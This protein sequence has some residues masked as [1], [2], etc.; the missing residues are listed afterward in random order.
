MFGTADEA[1]EVIGLPEGIQ[2]AESGFVDKA[3]RNAFPA[4]ERVGERYSIA[5]GE[6][7][8]NVIGHDDVAPQLVALPVEVMKAVSDDLGEAWIT[9][10]AVSVRGIEVFIEFVGELAV[11]AGF[12]DFV[13]R[14]R[15]RSE[16]GVTR[17][18][19]VIK[20]FTRQRIGQPKGDKDRHLALL[21]VRQLVGGLFDVPSRIEELHA[22]ANRGER[23]HSCPLFKWR[24]SREDEEA[25]RSVRAPLQLHASACTFFEAEM[26]V[27]GRRHEAEKGFAG[28]QGLAVAGLGR[29]NGAKN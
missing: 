8:M 15:I 27:S 13:P 20:E 17:T 9:Q 2:R 12:G 7:H 16:E 28:G 21:P 29:G 22:S 19:P 18:K 10:G 6:E 11:V 14:R 5:E 25:D 1:V 24:R 23:G 3:T 4:L 26:I